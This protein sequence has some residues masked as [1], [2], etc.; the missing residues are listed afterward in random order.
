MTD[1]DIRKA[2]REA[3]DA[4]ARWIGLNTGMFVERHLQCLDDVYRAGMEAGRAEAAS[5]PKRRKAAPCSVQRP[6]M[7]DEQTWAD[8]LKLRKDK[9]APVTQTVLNAATKEA[10]KAGMTLESFLQVWCYRG[11]QGLEAA[12]LTPQERSKGVPAESFQSQAAL[13]RVQ[14][15][16][17]GAARKDAGSGLKSWQE[18]IEGTIDAGQ[19]RLR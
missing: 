17:P 4:K 1:E 8:W 9:K 10:A 3:F 18:A 11:S 2:V 15:I 12:W 19:P 7:V 14:R 5:K 6:E 16:A 13:A